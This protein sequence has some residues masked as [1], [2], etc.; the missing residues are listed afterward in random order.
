MELEK[1][2][3]QQARPWL[4]RV[5]LAA[6]EYHKRA[7]LMEEL[8]AT[9]EEVGAVDYTHE[10]VSG[11][12]K[13]DRLAEYMDGLAL[14]RLE[15]SAAMATYKAEVDAAAKALRGID[16]EA[17]HLLAAYYLSGA[18]TLADAAKT[19]NEE[20]ERHGLKPITGSNLYKRHRDAL[21][22]AYEVTPA[23]WRDPRPRAY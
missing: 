8:E 18:E 19:M 5:R 22:A 20:R 9:A 23:P 15:A 13:V 6:R 4:E 16:P 1:Y 11:G 14:A 17:L 2:H 21:L 3:I 10:H 7:A 12:D